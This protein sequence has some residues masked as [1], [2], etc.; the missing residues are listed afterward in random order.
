MAFQAIPRDFIMKNTIAGMFI[1]AIHAVL[2]HKLMIMESQFTISHEMGLPVDFTRP[3]AKS[4]GSRTERII[5]E[6][7][8]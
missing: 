3:K 2:L 7:M 8:P 5:V 1:K 6:W 4:H